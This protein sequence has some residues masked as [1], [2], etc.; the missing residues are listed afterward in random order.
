MADEVFHTIDPNGDVLLILRSPNAPFAVWNVDKGTESLAPKRIGWEQA[1]LESFDPPPPTDDLDGSDFATHS[2]STKKMKKGKKKKKKGGDSSLSATMVSGSTSTDALS[3]SRNEPQQLSEAEPPATPST[4]PPAEPEEEPAESG[5]ETEIKY[6]VSSR[7]LTLASTKFEAEFKGPW[8]EGSVKNIDGYYP[9]NA[10]DWDPDALLILM[11]VFHGQTRSVPRQVG[12]EML[13]KIAVLVDYYDSP[14]VVEVFA[15]IWIGALKNKLPT[16]YGR[17]MVL[18]LLISHVFQQ[19]DVFSL[20][21]KIAV[22]QSTEPVPTLELPIPSI[23]TDLIDWQRQEAVDFI[24]KTLQTLLEAFRKGSS[25]CS[26]ECSSMLLGAL[27]KE[28]DRHKL[29]NPVPK[30]PYTG[31]SILDTNKIVNSF[32]CPHWNHRR[33]SYYM[34]YPDNPDS[35]NLKII[36]STLLKTQPNAAMEGF[37]HSEIQTLTQKR[38]PKIEDKKDNV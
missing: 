32:H 7:H 10:S 18:W 15:S 16:Q 8:M 12:L 1:V 22:I 3:W 5:K 34:D 29:L 2:I 11:R 33:D 36:I 14:E 31:Y 13:A 37:K 17:D 19:D 9:I 6:L 21:T 4:G 20:M 26:F 35:C 38:S 25:G 30:E 23:V 28:M 24:F 27:T